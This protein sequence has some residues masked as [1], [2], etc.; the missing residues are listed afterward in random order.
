MLL[1]TLLHSVLFLIYAALAVFII[2]KNPSGFLNLSIFTLMLVSSLMSLSLFVIRYPFIEQVYANIFMD[3]FT[4]SLTAYGALVFLSI[5]HF[6]RIFKPGIITY[7]ILSL[8]TF[9]FAV[10]QLVTGFGFVASR[11]S[12]GIWLMEFDNP[13]IL[14]VLDITHNLFLISG[15]VLLIIFIYKSTDVLKKKQAKTI[16]IAAL[17][18]YA[19]SLTNI[20]LSYF[21]PDM[22]LS[23]L[24]DLS[25]SVF[26]IGFIYSIVKFELFE[27]T[28][29]MVVEQ[30]IQYMPIGL[31]LTDNK[32]FISRTNNSLCSITEM[33]EKLL[34]DK[35]LDEVFQ[36]IFIEEKAGNIID[37]KRFKNIEIKTD[38]GSKSI[39]IFHKNLYDSLK[40]QTGSITLIH[41]IDDLI[42]TQDRLSESNKSLEERVENRTK[43][44]KIAKEKAELAN[45]LKTKFLNNISHEIRTPMNGIIGF[46][47]LVLNPDF[48]NEKKKYFSKIVKNSSKQLLRIIDDVLEISNLETKQE[49]VK[50]ESFCLN[51]LLTELYSIFSLKTKEKNLNLYLKKQ[52]SNEESLI[53]SDKSKLNKIMSNLIEN[54]VKFTTEGFVEFGYFFESENINLYVKD[55]G[56]GISH[57][58]HKLI[59]ERFAQENS[60][61]SKKKGGL[62]LGLSISKESAQLLGGDI[63]LESEKGKGSSFYVKLPY[64]SGV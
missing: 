11:N 63:S 51:E 44:L 55:T 10:Y 20:I 61:V 40:R 53:I 43:D 47:D 49:E 60:E 41:D 57:D 54:A 37:L 7:L 15:F 42:K 25:A 50:M 32:G 2:R 56:T 4:I 12:N 38:S 19:I 29:S 34:M 45:E 59:F 24:N 22:R 39:S 30:I 27:L 35:S 8:Y 6:T 48:S 26:L 1:E 31:I 36:N 17:I 16:F 33:D 64:E 3:V 5:L 13:V 28:P 46:S 21:Y 9:V 58:S 23:M 18:S 52:F 14:S 62:G